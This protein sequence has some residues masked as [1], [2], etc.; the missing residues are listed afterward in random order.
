M[1]NLLDLTVI[2]PVLQG[3]FDQVLHRKRTL[4]LAQATVGVCGTQRLGVNEV[5]RQMAVALGKSPKHC[6]KQFDRFLSNAGVELETILPAFLQWVVGARREILVAVDWTDFDHQDQTTL[7][8]S[9]ITK[10]GRATPLA[11]KTHQ[12]STLKNKRNGYEDALLAQVAAALPAETKVTLLAD[13]GF[14]DVKLY[15]FLAEELHWDFVI[16]F[17]GG[18]K[19]Q[20]EGVTQRAASQ[21]VPKNGRARMFRGARVTG[22]AVAVGAVVC[23]KKR[24]MKEAWCLATSRDDLPAKEVV[25]L[26]GQRFTIEET[27]RDEKDDR[28]GLGLKEVRLAAPGRRD[29][30]L[31]VLAVT[32]VLLTLLGKA[33]EDLGLDRKL[34]ANTR[35]AKRSHALFNQGRHYARGVAV[36]AGGAVNL[37]AGFFALLADMPNVVATLGWI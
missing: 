3:V 19:V 11:W 20:A 2:L 33:G 4:S 6:I 16:R 35:H 7:V 34:R 26:Y 30:M 1:K 21:L 22:K 10:H 8:L 15:T 23:V 24:A 31:L 12:K 36:A 18:V 14:G 28:F 29:R 17:R 37:L 5:G 25:K 9:L 27:F 13:R 32:R